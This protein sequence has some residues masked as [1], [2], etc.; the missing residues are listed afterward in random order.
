MAHEFLPRALAAFTPLLL[1]NIGTLPV[2][3]ALPADPPMHDVSTGN[4]WPASTA[5]RARAVAAIEDLRSQL[6][7]ANSATAVLDQWCASHGMAPTGAIVADRIGESSGPVPPVLRRLLRVGSNEPVGFRHVRLRCRNHIL[8]EAML[9]YVPGRLPGAMNRQL[10]ETNIPFGRVVAPLHFR[11][12][13]L[14]ERR[15]W[16]P[17]RV[18]APIGDVPAILFD[19]T[20]LIVLPDGAPIAYV[21][22]EYM[23]GVLD[24]PAPQWVATF[25]MELSSGH[26]CEEALAAF[27]PCHVDDV[28]V[29]LAD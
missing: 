28:R 17:E 1:L 26:P 8:S 5:G 14:S 19:Q 11:R 4:S 15:S 29:T 10:L 22:E 21:R 3:Q 2:G 27:T 23:P 20:A 12:R 13:A 6:R 16:P 24:Y 7:T 9:W 25:V 18:G